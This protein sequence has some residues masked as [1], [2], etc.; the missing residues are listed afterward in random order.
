MLNKIEGGWVWNWGFD[1]IRLWETRWQ[2]GA[3]FLKVQVKSI[4]ICTCPK[5]VAMLLGSGSWRLGSGSWRDC[6]SQVFNGSSTAFLVP[7]P[8]PSSRQ[9]AAQKLGSRTRSIVRG[10]W[11][12]GWAEGRK[13]KSKNG[14]VE[15]CKTEKR[16]RKTRKVQSRNRPNRTLKNRTPPN[17]LPRTPNLERSD[18]NSILI[19]INY[20]W[21]LQQMVRVRRR[22]ERL[23]VHHLS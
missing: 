11:K 15:K 10:C 14:K 5:P 22:T 3:S 1:H 8:F 18:S 6:E 13:P 23:C 21:R 4:T 20:V 7:L 2:C 19:H 9:H 16:N 12:S 17:R